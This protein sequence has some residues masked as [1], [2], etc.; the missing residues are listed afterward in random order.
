MKGRAKIRYVIKENMESS[1]R[2]GK[3][4]PGIACKVAGYG[5]FIDH[6]N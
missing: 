2:E 1:H 6:V 3:G 5:V 4:A